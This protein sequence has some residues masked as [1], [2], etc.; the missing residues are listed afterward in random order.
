MPGT[1]RDLFKS[2]SQRVSETVGLAQ[3]QAG[4]ANSQQVVSGLVAGVAAA[5]VYQVD[6]SAGSA[7]VGGQLA[8]SAAVLS[9]ALPAG[10]TTTSAQYVNL[11]VELAWVS[12]TSGVIT[13]PSVVITAGAY[14]ASA[15]AAV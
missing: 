9:T 14:A 13:T 7:V 15:A 3:L 11:L 4:Q 5:Q 12:L 10:A 2:H 1:P 6:V 8:S